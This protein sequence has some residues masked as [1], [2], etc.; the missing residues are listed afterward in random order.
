MDSKERK[1]QHRWEQKNRWMAHYELK[2]GVVP[3]E[4][5]PL[6]AM[7]GAPAILKAKCRFC[8]AFG[9]ETSLPHP[10]SD[11]AMALGMDFATTPPPSSAGSSGSGMHSMDPS[12]LSGQPLAKRRK[13][14]QT[15]KVF[16]PNFRTDNLESHLTREHPIKWKEYERLRD[17][18]KKLFFPESVELK[19]RSSGTASGA[20]GDQAPAIH[21]GANNNNNVHSM[22]MGLSPSSMLSGS[23]S[24][25]MAFPSGA[26]LEKSSISMKHAIGVPIMNMIDQLLFN[27]PW[28]AANGGTNAVDTPST[29][30]SAHW[31][32]Q[33]IRM[34][35]S[36]TGDVVLPDVKA[37]NIMSEAEEVAVVTIPSE[38]VLQYMVDA[39]SSGL[40]FDAT[41]AMAHTTQRLM[42]E[43]T[44]LGT[45]SRADIL[46][47]VRNIVAL[48]ISSIAMLLSVSWGFSLV[49]RFVTHHSTGYLDIRVE[50]AVN[51]EVHDVHLLAVPLE[52]Q[53]HS[54]EMLCAVI[55]KSLTCL[56]AHAMEKLVGV[57]VDGDPYH[58][59]KY[60]QIAFWLR[61]EVALVASHS[62]F[63]VL[64]SGAYHIN[65]VLEE[66]LDLCQSD[67]AF[68]SSLA[69]LDMLC[70]SNKSLMLLLGP[71]PA[72]NEAVHWISIFN[73]CEWLAMHRESL[74]KWCQDHDELHRLPSNTWWV[75]V[76]LMRDLFKDVHAVYKK[77]HETATSANDVQRH[78]R[79]LV[80]QFRLKFNI[81]TPVTMSAPGSP[82]SASAELTLNDSLSDPNDF[83]YQ[84][85]VNAIIPLDLFMYEAFQLK[86]IDG[87]GEAE[88]TQVYDRFSVLIMQLLDRL[89]SIAS[90]SP[91]TSSVAAVT[92][93][94]SAASTFP[95][96]HQYTNNI[97]PSTPYEL[98]TMDNLA[99]ME[100]L[101][102]Q[103]HRIRSKWAG[104][105]LTMITEDRNRMVADFSLR[106]NFYE[107]VSLTAK[108][109]QM[110][111]GGFR[112]MWKVASTSLEYP[113][114]CSFAV[115][116]GTL[117]S[118]P[119]EQ[120]VRGLDKLS[121][122]NL[123][124]E[125]QLHSQQFHRVNA[126]RKHVDLLV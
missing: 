27:R 13:K 3:M 16:G 1:R 85:F 100:L 32:H 113:S 47:T 34:E 121:V 62:A 11:D 123:A 76:F 73:T 87:V 12:G 6:Q 55:V 39:L 51:D 66:L 106:D 14:R 105:V 65:M 20:T 75:L 104:K 102:S 26:M 101:N 71:A 86:S 31:W 72:T 35:E 112:D 124:L 23:S 44:W 110:G 83:T 37:A 25:I 119:S 58:M 49:L 41:L 95:E 48:N 108:Q 67:F 114:L 5:G 97:P 70:Q 8:E 77:L 89:Q 4:F 93:G 46:G 2:Y 118:V 10:H 109:Q 45:L 84:D 42:P 59:D 50:L 80:F 43:A 38:S 7:D 99:F 111:N 74:V 61:K 90:A 91:E 79:E 64:Y 53:K 122:S 33:F 21:T 82:S 96:F 17:S 78:L 117:L 29:S 116:L 9:R 88:R 115:V 54:A 120:N 24:K 60:K 81:K 98:I 94:I 125:A 15:L 40:S 57:T 36:L 63:Y 30:S 126:L 19:D 28:K 52:A 69:D 22:G 92:V 56:D 103:Q 107:A 18:E 68:L